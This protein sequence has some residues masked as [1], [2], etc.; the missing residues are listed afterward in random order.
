[1][2]LKLATAAVLMALASRAALAASEGGDT[3][4]ELQPQPYVASQRAAYDSSVVVATTANRAASEGGDTWS[5]LQPQPTVASERAA[6]DSSVVVATT[7][8]LSGLRSEQPSAALGTPV[9]DSAA[10]RVVQLGPRSHWVNVG[11][12]ETIEFVVPGGNGPERSF[13][14]RFD[15]MP[16][17]TMVDLSEVAPAQFLDHEVQVF[18]G[19]D[20]L[21]NG[22]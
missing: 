11:Y 1:M 4:S 10:D 5:E 16:E 21:Y 19:P 9:Q 2:K 12:G 14:W 22:D 6:S 18:V 3:W 7:A 15:V 17:V 8:S 13:A 20:P